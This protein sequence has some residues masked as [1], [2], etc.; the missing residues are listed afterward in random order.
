[1]LALFLSYLPKNKCFLNLLKSE[2]LQITVA[3]IFETSEVYL[4]LGNI[5]GGLT[6]SVTQNC[7]NVNFTTVCDLTSELLSTQFTPG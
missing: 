6:Y 4:S 3:R 2:N 7:L 5:Q 1:M